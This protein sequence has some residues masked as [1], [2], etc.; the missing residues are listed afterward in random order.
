MAV[1]LISLINYC[2]GE[3]LQSNIYL[4]DNYDVRCGLSVLSTHLA[5]LSKAQTVAFISLVWCALRK[6]FNTHVKSGARLAWEVGEHPR[7]HLP[8]LYE[9]HVARHPGQQAHAEGHRHG[10]DL[11]VCGGLDTLPLGPNSGTERLGD[12][13]LGCRN[14]ML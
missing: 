10:T 3:V 4:L 13:S 2:D 1:Y 7:L 12:R 11:L 9:P 14:R 8:V 6:A 5:R